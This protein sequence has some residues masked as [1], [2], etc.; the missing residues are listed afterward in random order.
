MGISANQARLNTLTARK[1]DLQYRLTVL[2]NQTQIL[3][4]KQAEAVAK[5]VA[6]IQEYTINKLSE[7]NDTVSVS[8]EYSEE[9]ADY[10]ATMLELEAA[11]NRLD[12]QRESI[13][14][15]NSAVE[16]E[17]EEVK[18]LI[19]SNAKESFGIFSK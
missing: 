3:S 15:Q 12:L 17:E 14:T 13:E 11:E 8:F 6:A 18:K 16:Q 10:E 2:S 9:Y 1:S 4:T 7:D 5:K 19:E